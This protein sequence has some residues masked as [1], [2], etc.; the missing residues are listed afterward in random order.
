MGEVNGHQG[1]RPPTP[2]DAT[3]IGNGGDGNSPLTIGP[4]RI[5]RLIG[6]GG[7]G[8]V[9][10]GQQESPRRDVAIKVMNP[11]VVS[12]TAMRRFEFEA[13][14][15]A[16]LQHQVIAQVYE[17][18]TFDDGSGTRPY[19]A[20]EYISSAKELGDYI[21]A[22][23]LDV[24]SRLELFRRICEGIEYGHQ[25]GV[26]HRDLKPGNILVGADGQPKIIDFGVARSTDS[27][28]VSATLSTESGQLIGTL[29]Y[30]SPEQVDLDPADLDTRSDVYSL[31]VLLHEVLT[32]EFPYELTGA[33]ITKAAQRI[34]ESRPRRLGEIDA[35]F[36]GDLETICLK[37]LEKDRDRRYQSVGDLSEDIRR[38]LADEAI[39]ARQPRRTEQLR[40]FVRKHRLAS[41][42]TVVVSLALLAL[43]ILSAILYENAKGNLTQ[44]RKNFE[45]AMSFN[46]LLTEG[47]GSLSA[48]DGGEQLRDTIL[49]EANGTFA[50]TLPPDERDSQLALL[51]KALEPVN[52]TDV[53]NTYLADSM[54]LP[55][56]GGIDAL[57]ADDPY[58]HGAMLGKMGRALRGLG[59]EEVAETQLRRSIELLEAAVQ[60]GHKDLLTAQA[61]LATLLFRM[62]KGTEAEELY[63]SV[64]PGYEQAWGAENIRTLEIQDAIGACLIRQG[65]YEEGSAA[66]GAGLE[67]RRRLFGDEDYRTLNVMD[68][69][70]A[71]LTYLD[72]DEEAERYAREAWMGRRRNNGDDSVGA[73][74]A[75]SF[76]AGILVHLERFKEAEELMQPVLPVLRQ[77]HGNDHAHTLTAMRHWS[78][79]LA[80]L[81]RYEEAEALLQ[82]R[83]QLCLTG[84]G[85]DHVNT[86]EARH[87]LGE[88]YITME[89]F[90]DALPLAKVNERTLND[91]AWANRR[92]A[93]EQL[94]ELHEAWHGVDPEG[95]HDATAAEYQSRLDTIEAA[96][97]EEPAPAVP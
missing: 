18:G 87:Q 22:K 74:R 3:I 24:H 12:H 60:P 20:M 72:R 32:G 19:F 16:R 34:K 91:A 55:M 33:S 10:L 92:M 57:F 38:Y 78:R 44:A 53:T 13:Q 21:E 35:K 68:N 37:A 17:A 43:T 96:E 86:F 94:V 28:A 58:W 11:G 79:S 31:G 89:R 5:K 23:Q 81:E 95:G 7:M 40:R 45:V 4:Y 97:A 2:D 46:E 76:L 54:I 26:I 14:V 42:A 75:Q 9:Y 48:S 82:E 49:N 90:E 47:L 88:L 63:R 56:I 84:W 51:E 69:Y 59:Q 67:T 83:L 1:D 93:L 77:R 61:S 62:G 64:L 27:D 15:L 70:A 73:M 30:M 36:K 52:F 39:M 50:R 41:A 29:Q 66:I 71:S 65:R 85:D 6:A 80:G 8:T 25:R